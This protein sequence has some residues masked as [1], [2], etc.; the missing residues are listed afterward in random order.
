MFQG[1]TREDALS[2]KSYIQSNQ[3]AAAVVH[4]RIIQESRLQITLNA[5]DFTPNKNVGQ[6]SFETH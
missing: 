4:T 3:L 5:E 2:W 6:L 1:R